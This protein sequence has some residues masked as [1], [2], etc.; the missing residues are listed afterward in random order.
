MSRF[1]VSQSS[2]DKVSR[3]LLGDSVG[4]SSKFLAKIALG[5][6]NID[7]GMCHHPHDPAD[8]KRMIIFLEN[9]TSI[10][11]AEVLLTAS[12]YSREWS[13]IYYNFHEL[14]EQ[15]VDEKNNKQAPLLY[16]LMKQKFSE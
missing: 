4:L 11:A 5:L 1:E 6:H 14:Y 12:D 7:I 15:W 16:K 3:W 8:F 2:K 9:L 10:E 13:A